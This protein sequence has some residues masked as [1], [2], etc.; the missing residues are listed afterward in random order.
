MSREGNMWIYTAEV[1]GTENGAPTMGIQTPSPIPSLGSG[2][3]ILEA[4]Q[5]FNMEASHHIVLSDSFF[6]VELITR[7]RYVVWDF[8]DKRGLLAAKP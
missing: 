5:A 8:S 1:P 2:L 6:G 7:S 4:I 3:M